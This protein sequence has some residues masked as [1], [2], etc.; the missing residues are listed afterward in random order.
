[1]RSRKPVE[2]DYIQALDDLDTRT[3]F[4]HRKF[5]SKFGVLIE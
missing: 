5:Y 2:V 4:I 1:M 3:H